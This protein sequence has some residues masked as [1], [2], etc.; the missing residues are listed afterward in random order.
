MFLAEASIMIHIKYVAVLHWYS[1]VYQNIGDA[2]LGT[3]NLTLGALV[4]LG[5]MMYEG[6]QLK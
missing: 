4:V 6:S 1:Q 5:Y 3:A 2:H